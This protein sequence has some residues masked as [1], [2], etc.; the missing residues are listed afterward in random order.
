MIL[1]EHVKTSWLIFWERLFILAWFLIKPIL[2]AFISDVVQT[3]PW[4]DDQLCHTPKVS[5]FQQIQFYLCD[6]TLGNILLP[7]YRTKPNCL[8]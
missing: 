3:A 2:E 8:S 6:V 5:R 4:L 7:F 1:L